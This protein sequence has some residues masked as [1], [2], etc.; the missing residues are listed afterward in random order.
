M[1]KCHLRLTDRERQVHTAPSVYEFLG[2]T[3]RYSTV[4]RG[5]M[6]DSLSTQVPLS[7]FLQSCHIGTGNGGSVGWGSPTARRR[8]NDHYTTTTATLATGSRQPIRLVRSTPAAPTRPTQTNEA[9]VPSWHRSVVIYHAGTGAYAGAFA[10]LGDEISCPA[11]YIQCGRG[12][13]SPKDFMG[14]LESGGPFGRC[15]SVAGNAALEF[16]WRLGCCE[17]LDLI[18]PQKLLIHE[19]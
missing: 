12:H 8:P 10:L 14:L 11:L 4:G 1:L 13:Y 9:V 18:L 5:P 17:M 16:D 3:M 2:W 19:L 6:S 7:R 15:A